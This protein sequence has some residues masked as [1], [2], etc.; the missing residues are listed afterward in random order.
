MCMYLRTEPQNPWSKKDRI[1]RRNNATGR[2]AEFN[3]SIL[4]ISRTTRQRLSKDEDYSPVSQ[5]D[6]WHL[7]KTTHG[8]SRTHILLEYMWHVLQAPDIRPQNWSQIFKTWS[9]LFWY[10]HK[11][12]FF[13]LVFTWYFSH[14]FIFNLSVCW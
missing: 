13:Q 14:S 12:I 6:T 9:F 8:R 3:N 11:T 5:L 2:V 1:E 10:L 4:V 7:W